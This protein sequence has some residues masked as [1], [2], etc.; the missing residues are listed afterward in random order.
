KRI[1]IYGNGGRMLPLANNIYYPDD[2]TE[3]AI[4]VS[5][6]NDGVFNNEDYILFYGEG[7]D[8][9]NTESQTNINIFDSKSY[10][11][12]TTS[13]G[14]GKRIAALNQPT[15]NSTLELNTY[16]DYQYHEI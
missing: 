9:W 11:Y 5:G 4:Q 15:N 7:V 1:K 13:G 8:N 14:D 3:N 16:D 6:E 2:L 12:I 10:Y